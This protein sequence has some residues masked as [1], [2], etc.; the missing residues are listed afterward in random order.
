[1]NVKHLYAERVP[2]DL[3]PYFSDHM[4]AMTG[5]KLHSKAAIAM[6]LAYRDKL[7][8]EHFDNLWLITG[9]VRFDDDDSAIVIKAI[10]EFDAN[11]VFKEQLAT[12][13]DTSLD[14][15]IICSATALKNA[16]A[17]IKE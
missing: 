7:Y 5:E 9:R 12:E 11:K 4:S 10:N 1:M 14:D 17:N 13:R 15:I 2:S 16:L 8:A 6:E 3:E